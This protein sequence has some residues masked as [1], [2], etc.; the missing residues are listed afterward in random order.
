MQKESPKEL[1][2]RKCHDFLYTAVSVVLPL[3][4]DPLSIEGDEAVIRNGDAM[5]I[6][7]EIPQHLQRS[8]ERGFGVNHPAPQMQS[9]EQLRKLFR[10]GKEGRRAAA[11]E[12]AAL[13][14]P[15]QSCNELAAKAFPEYWDRQ[16]EITPRRNPMA[17]A[18]G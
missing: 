14:P 12:L 16:E 8:A 3:K 18:G 6:A 13:T 10:I 4:T 17:V 15:F 11:G 9:P 2:G 1:R 5:R 7:A